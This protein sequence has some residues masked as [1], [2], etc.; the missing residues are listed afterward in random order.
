M[1]VVMRDGEKG[2]KDHYICSL[3]FLSLHSFS[4]KNKADNFRNNSIGSDCAAIGHE[5]RFNKRKRVTLNITIIIDAFG[6]LTFLLHCELKTKYKKQVSSVW[7]PS[8]VAAEVAP[9][10]PFSPVFP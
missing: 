6:K 5:H 7:E 4:R 8:D 3:R 2:K 9:A 1:E 10:F